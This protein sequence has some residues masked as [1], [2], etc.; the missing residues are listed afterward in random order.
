MSSVRG[1]FVGDSSLLMG[2]VD[3]FV[4]AGHEVA[5]VATKDARVRAW[6]LERGFA[7]FGKGEGL[8]AEVAKI[9]FDYLFSVANLDMIAPEVIEKARVLAINFHDGPLPRYA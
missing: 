6:V 2:C 4:A 9:S 1:F 5:G 3:M 7:A 8:S